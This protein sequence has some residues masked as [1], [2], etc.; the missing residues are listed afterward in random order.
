MSLLHCFFEE[1]ADGKQV[2]IKVRN[3]ED[4]SLIYIYIYIKVHKTFDE[5]DVGVT[6][7]S[8]C[9]IYVS[10]D[11]CFIYIKGRT[12]KTNIRFYVSAND[13]NIVWGKC[14]VMGL[15]IFQKIKSF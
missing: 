9:D 10:S 6:T 3:E 12:H 5:I 4:L 8:T 14:V 2:E 11:F 13:I 1:G 15:L 7:L